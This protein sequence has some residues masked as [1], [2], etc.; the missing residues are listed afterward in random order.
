MLLVTLRFKER[1]APSIGTGRDHRAAG[2]LDATLAA[3]LLPAVIERLSDA[4]Q[5]QL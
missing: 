4:G 2:R 5:P 1:S 3:T